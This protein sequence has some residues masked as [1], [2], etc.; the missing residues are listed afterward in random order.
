MRAAWSVF[1]RSHC[2]RYRSSRFASGFTTKFRIQQF[3]TMHCFF[4]FYELA[5][6]PETMSSATTHLESERPH[7][8]PQVELSSLRPM[9][10]PTLTCTLCFKPHHADDLNECTVCYDLVCEHYPAEACSCA[11]SDARHSHRMRLR[12]CAL[13]LAA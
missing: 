5:H 10:Q 9:F 6:D 8:M 11:D 4:A 12:A 1:C 2:A 7:P 3:S 13:E